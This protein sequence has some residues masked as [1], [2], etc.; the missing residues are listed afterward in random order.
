MK[1]IKFALLVVF[2]G[3]NSVSA[4]DN[5]K[6]DTVATITDFSGSILVKK[7]VAG[8]PWKQARLYTPLEKDD[9][10][11]TEAG[12]MAEI[13]MEDGSIFKIEQNTELSL[14]ALEYSAETKKQNFLMT[15][16]KG[17]LMSSVE[18]TGNAESRIT[19]RTPTAVLSV[20]GTEFAVEVEDEDTTNVGVYS[21]LVTARNYTQDG[22]VSTEETMV[23]PDQETIVKRFQRPVRPYALKERLAQRRE[24]FVKMRERRKVIRENWKNIVA[25]RVKI[26]Q[27]VRQEVRKK[28]QE[29]P[30]LK[31]KIKQ[32]MKERL[33]QKKQPR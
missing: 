10:I 1:T 17:I 23:K 2:L 18:K 27:E 9:T 8:S 28:V 11:K 29:N 26:R 15:L 16:F 4:V 14:L 32:K 20:R 31:E 33:Q 21:G 13:T 25:N 3:L 5:G 22:N 24:M 7:S 19:V 12:A 30:Q 6:P